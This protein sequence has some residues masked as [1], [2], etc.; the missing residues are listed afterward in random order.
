[1]KRLLVVLLLIFSGSNLFSQIKISVKEALKHIGDSVVVIDKVYSGKHLENG[2]TLLN[3]GG[4]YPNQLLVVMI[5]PKHRA[6]FSFKPEEQFKGKRVIISGIIVDYKS[7]PEIVITNPS[8][9]IEAD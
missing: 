3:V 7:K 6:M 1:M 9:I 2:L 4:D 8:Q 5:K